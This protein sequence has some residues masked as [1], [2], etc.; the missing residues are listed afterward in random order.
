M[1]R[2]TDVSQ[3]RKLTQGLN[4]WSFKPWQVLLWAA[5]FPSFLHGQVENTAFE[6]CE[7]PLPY[8]TH[9]S[10]RPL[11]S[12]L[13]VCTCWSLRGLPASSCSQT[14]MPRKKRWK[15][16]C[17]F[18]LTVYWLQTALSL[19]ASPLPWP[20]EESA[21]GTAPGTNESEAQLGLLIA[22][23]LPCRARKRD[24]SQSHVRPTLMGWTAD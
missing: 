21:G 12:L 13:S 18:L 24:K 1:A 23:P 17:T 22:K 19:T 8:Y 14:S 15:H 11:E 3:S 20:R 2:P 6:L 7:A 10:G 9:C 5:G 4:T 16:I